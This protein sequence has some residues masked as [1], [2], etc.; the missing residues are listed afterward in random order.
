MLAKP[1]FE[2]ECAIWNPRH[3]SIEIRASLFRR[4]MC[5][6]KHKSWPQIG[7]LIKTFPRLGDWTTECSPQKGAAAFFTQIILGPIP[8]GC[9]I[10]C[11]FDGS[12]G[13]GE[14]KFRGSILAAISANGVEWPRRRN[15]S[16]VVL[17]RNNDYFHLRFRFRTLKSLNKTNWMIIRFCHIPSINYKKS[18]SVS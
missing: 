17:F 14:K 3:T 16:G 18:N 15:L 11:G 8:G 4:E 9:P 10:S 1:K 2:L 6:V 5:S 13:C 12:S 7:H